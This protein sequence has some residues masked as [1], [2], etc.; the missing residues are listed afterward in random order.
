MKSPFKFNPH[1]LENEDLVKILKDTW[2]AYSDNLHDSPASHFASNLKSMKV[3]STAWSVKQKEIEY[4]EL[5]EIEILISAFSLKFAFGFSFDEDKAALID[6]E[7]RKRKIL[8]DQE[9]E[10]R[11]KSRAIWLMCGDDN[12]P[13]F[14]KFANQRK[15]ANSI[16]NIKDD[17]GDMVEGFE[18][19]AGAGV[20]HFETLFQVDTNL[21]LIELLEISGNFPSSITAEE[22][23][24]LMKPVTLEEIKSILTIS[25]NDKSLRP[26]GIPVEVY[27]ALFD[28][29]GLDLLRVIED[30]RRSGKIPAVFNST[31]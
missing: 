1:W 14:H 31:L 30:F 24:D 13:F 7:T 28:V 9:H 26:D 19:I 6:L 12:T 18:A 10:A 27:R 3:V 29:M 22:N 23:C 21:H 11:Q 8:L 4:K 15:N 5:V 16:W 2:V 17:R 20:Q 25:K